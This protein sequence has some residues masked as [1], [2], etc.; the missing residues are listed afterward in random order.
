MY[1]DEM[2]NPEAI[3]NAARQSKS[4][5]NEPIDPGMFFEQVVGFKIPKKKTDI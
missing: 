1:I 4:K 2:L 5:P 3:K